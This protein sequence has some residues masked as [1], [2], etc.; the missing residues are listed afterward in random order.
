MFRRCQCGQ[1]IDMPTAEEC[2]CCHD[3]K[4]VTQIIDDGSD[5][6]CIVHHEGFEAVCLNKY[7]VQVAVYQ[8]KEDKP[9]EMK[10][11]SLHE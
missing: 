4:Q 6:K 1:C 7:A 8:H 11:K 10:G 2:V 5:V 9:R 3:I